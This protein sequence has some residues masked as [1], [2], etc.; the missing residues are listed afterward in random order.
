MKQ[1]KFIPYIFAIAC[2]AVYISLV[3]NNNVWLDEAFSASI[4]R[5]DFVEM[6]ARTFADTLPPFYNFSAWLFT[7]IF[8]FSTVSLKIFS[9]MPMT[10]LMLISAHF[11]PKFSSVRA[12]CIYIA[13]LT[14]MPHFLEYGVEIRMYSQAICFASATAIFALCL[15]H[16]I[17]HSALW[18]IITTV[19]GAY[20]HQYALIA[21]AFVWLMLLFVYIR[22]KSFSGWLRYAV[23]CIVCYIPCAVLTIYQMK[24][25]VPYFSASPATLSN[26]MSSM[27]YPFV[28]HITILSALLMAFALILLLYAC[29]KGKLAYAYYILV[30]VLVTMLSFG[31]MSATGS[32]FFSSR[33]LLPAIGILWLGTALSL[34]SMLSENKYVWF[35]AVPLITVSLIVLYVQQFKAE[36]VDTSA[37]EEFISSTDDKDGYVIYEDFPEIEICLGYYAPWLKKYDLKDIKKAEGNKYVFVN[38]D[39][40][41][42]DIAEIKDLKFDLGYVENLNFDRYTFGVYILSP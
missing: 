3:F 34:D 21:E 18:L 29:T 10:L 33:Y 31:L 38:G 23:I 30:Y 39:V 5:C 17:P 28:T 15:L 35:V 20:T 32:T 24:S 11:I 6:A 26:M 7:H 1:S 9:V 8:G 4:I 41:T 27:R 2:T 42:D 40:H 12:A 25:A 14:A 16:D 36:Y 22:N 19:L 13:L 37:F